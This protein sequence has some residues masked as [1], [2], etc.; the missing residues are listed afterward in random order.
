MADFFQHM[1]MR[2]DEK[3]T[4]WSRLLVC[5]NCGSLVDYGRPMLKGHDRRC[6]WCPAC[7]PNEP[8]RYG[9]VVDQSSESK[10]APAA[11]LA[12]LEGA[13]ELLDNL[14]WIPCS[15]RMPERGNLTA[16]H[17]L[18]VVSNEHSRY[19]E[20]GYW[21]GDH[22]CDVDSYDPNTW[23]VSEVTHW[24]PLPEPPT[25]LEERSTD[26]EKP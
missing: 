22:W 8:W 19:V 2:E 13:Q 24:Q 26:L 4:H 15:K 9:E 7:A 10:R 21:A 20:H 18:F 23:R 6:S 16:H 5:T 14:K 1:H 12:S 11:R 17:V 25:P 3:P